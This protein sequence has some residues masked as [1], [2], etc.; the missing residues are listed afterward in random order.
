M[1]RLSALRI[2]AFA[3][4]S[5]LALVGAAQAQDYGAAAAAAAPK[6][7]LGEVTLGAVG[8]TDTSAAFGRYNGLA[9]SGAELTG[10]WNLRSRDAWDSGG[11]NFWNS[12]GD[13]ISAGLRKIAPEASASFTTGEQ[14]AWQL[15]ASYDA[16]TYAASNNFTTILDSRG[17]LVTGYQN[18]L[19]QQ[20]AY[21][22][23]VAASPG[24]LFSAYNAS[25]HLAT[26]NPITAYG[27]GNMVVDTIGTRRDKGS[28]DGAYYIGD[29]SITTGL[30]DE[31]KE[32]TLEQTM[33]TG[34]NNAGMV[35]FPMPINYDTTIYTAAA[36][37]DT[38]NLQAKFSYQ[39]SNFVD[40]NGAGYAFQ[41]WNF[42]AYNNPT[43]KT[44]T[45]YA[46]NGNYSLPASNQAHTFTGELA[47]NFDS[48]TRIASTAVYGIQMQNASF[49]ES[50]DIGYIASVPGQPLAAQLGSNP[51][52]LNGLV[53]TFFGNVVFTAQ[54]LPK[55]NVKA[56][57]KVDARSPHTSAKFIYGDP[58]DTTALKFRQ[59]VPAS[60]TKQE[61]SLTADY[62][63][64][65]ETK[66][67]VGYT[68]RDAV[69]SNAITHVAEDNEFTA[70]IR[71]SLSSGITGSLSYLHANRSAS[72]PDYSLWLTQIQSDCGSTLVGLG[73]QQVPYY[74]AARV[75][76]T[77]KGNLTGMLGEQT[78]FT[79]FGKYNNDS[80]HDPL[81]VYQASASLPVTTNPSV[82]LNRDYSIQAGP[83]LA[84]QIDA[85]DEVHFFY[86]F[87]R[88]YRNMRAL[89]AQSVVGG[90]NEYA[91]ASTYDIHTVGA[92]GTWQA[93]DQLKIVGDYTFSYAGQAFAQSGTWNLNFQGD[94]SL[95]TKDAD[96]QV[97]VHAL[98]EYS[99]RTT[100]YL[101]YQFD[102][103]SM[104]DFALVGKLA[105]FVLTGDLAPKYNIS[106]VSAGLTLKL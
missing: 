87:L 50:T 59:A 64:L 22:T 78:S 21:F 34:G 30:S 32:G 103:V 61:V 88:E 106:T 86:T 17:N 43:A 76:D 65:P 6:V 72:K 85:T 47:Y 71:S 38:D 20:N 104:T 19:I 35:A 101:G 16:M 57:Y 66:V 14:G 8:V 83:D 58:T 69:R 1:S 26:A 55:L 74:E 73:C 27:P 80:Y 62:H 90:S 5:L 94:P 23:N 81:A 56:S 89:N 96:N 24:T 18:A 42:S 37:Y 97:K 92:G 44:F 102:S 10:G 33:T 46:K 82:G 84:Y 60:W 2:A 93:S 51:T 45:S 7:S 79:L 54:P 48:T 31:H 13:N 4:V 99:P 91:V 67:S 63:L 15:S 68:Y 49:V 41:G 52:S 70:D 100:L 105:G 12:T 36:A 25:T 98:Y 40:H 77:V 53:E 39:H 9:N 3:S 95:S 75:Q 28:L 11:T 29:W